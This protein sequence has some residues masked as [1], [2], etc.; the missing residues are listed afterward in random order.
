MKIL[1]YILLCVGIVILTFNGFGIMT[2]QYWAIYLSLT[3]GEFLV[4]TGDD[5]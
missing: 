2:W 4:C 3:F 5:L 1:G